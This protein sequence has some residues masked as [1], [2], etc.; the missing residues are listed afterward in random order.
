VSGR[1][2]V[3]AGSK[4]RTHGG[5]ER[6]RRGKA[7]THP[8]PPHPRRRLHTGGPDF[9][10]GPPPPPLRPPLRPPPLLL[11]QRQSQRRLDPR[12]R[13]VREDILTGPDL[14]A[15]DE[16][17]AHEVHTHTRHKH[18]RPPAPSPHIACLT[19]S[20][21]CCGI[22]CAHAAGGSGAHQ[23]SPLTA[24]YQHK[25]PG[26]VRALP[27]VGQETEAGQHEHTHHRQHQAP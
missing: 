15:H 5:G 21:M 6:E 7:A 2:E 11:R 16:G 9:A 3:T 19:H 23:P 18:D 27:E 8:T 10:R 20:S 13:A 25:G 26:T 22:R 17:W 24:A 12:R 14:M 1:Q 4:S